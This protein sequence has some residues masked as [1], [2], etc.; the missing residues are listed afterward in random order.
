[1]SA[2]PN[3]QWL[4]V[5]HI[6]SLGDTIVTIPALRAV[7]TEWPR[8]RLALLTTSGHAATTARDVLEGDVLVDDFV[9]YR[10]TGP[11]T[12]VLREVWRVAR[13]IRRRH[14]DRVVCLLPSARNASALRRDRLFF[15]A[16][17][18]RHFHGYDVTSDGRAEQDWSALGEHQRKLTRLAADGVAAARAE[19]AWMPLLTLRRSEREAG[20]SLLASAAP[21]R[22]RLAMAVV[23][24]WDSKNWPVQRFLEIGRRAHAIGAEIV[25]VGG[26]ADGRVFDT[27]MAE[28]GFGVNACGHPVRVTAAA[29]AGCQAFVGPDSGAAHLAASVGT[30]CVVASWAG[31]VPR[32]WDPIGDG[33][34]VVRVPVPC[35][36]CQSAWCRTPGHPC[37]TDLSVEGVWRALAPL[38]EAA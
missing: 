17:G 28:W 5:H 31:S 22:A 8:H 33:H 1:M 38:L 29:L 7:R 16:C 36:G 11:R 6:G 2:T 25:G 23:S 27:L 21:G 24:N 13:T 14:I 19:H 35:E 3:D 37:I 15:R 34:L 20:T 4:L 12:H 9:E 30:P 18:V 32:Q 10:R 26:S